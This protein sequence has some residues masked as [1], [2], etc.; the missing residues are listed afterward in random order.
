M[1]AQA[2]QPKL[3]GIRG[4]PHLFQGQQSPCAYDGLCCIGELGCE[5]VVDLLVPLP[6]RAGDGYDSHACPP[7][8]D[9][10]QAICYSE[11]TTRLS[12]GVILRL[13]LPR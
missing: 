11:G 9:T 12:S 13:E 7:H 1:P 2:Y 6:K 4:G 5:R 10:Q 3:G 8:L